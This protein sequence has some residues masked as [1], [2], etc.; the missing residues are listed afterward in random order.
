MPGVC[1]L[2]PWYVCCLVFDYVINVFRRNRLYRYSSG[3]TFATCTADL[4]EYLN[5]D[6]VHAKYPRQVCRIVQITCLRTCDFSS[7]ICTIYMSMYFLLCSSG[8]KGNYIH[9]LPKQSSVSSE[10]IQAYSRT[11]FCPNKIFGLWTHSREG[12]FLCL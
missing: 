6:D 3:T 4:D 8:T 12:W 11:R 9:L 2:G 10:N 5:A 1:V 7:Q